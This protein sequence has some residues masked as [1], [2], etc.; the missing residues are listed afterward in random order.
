MIFLLILQYLPI[1]GFHWHSRYS[2]GY[3]GGICLLFRCSVWFTGSSCNQMLGFQFVW[4][5]IKFLPSYFNSTAHVLAPF[6]YFWSYLS[7]LVSC[8]NQELRSLIFCPNHLCLFSCII[9]AQWRLHAFLKG[10]IL[11]VT[12][13]ISCVNKAIY[14]ILYGKLQLICDIYTHAQASFVG[15]NKIVKMC[16]CVLVIIGS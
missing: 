2:T 16:I 9:T 8:S 10:T 6:A 1:C 14:Y 13:T 15:S 4:F 11:C 7:F 3:L 12:T 5:L